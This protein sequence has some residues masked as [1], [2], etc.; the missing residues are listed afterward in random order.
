MVVPLLALLTAYQLATTVAA[1]LL[2]NTKKVDDS[3][4]AGYT[5]KIVGAKQSTYI[6]FSHKA[7]ASDRVLPCLLDS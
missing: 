2:S 4:L 6:R 5:G 1:V 3:S 7:A